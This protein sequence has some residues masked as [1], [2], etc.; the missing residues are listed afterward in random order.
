VGSSCTAAIRAGAILILPGA[1]LVL[2]ALGLIV[3][4]SLAAPDD[5]RG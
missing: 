1:L 5:D 4:A 2:V 3:R